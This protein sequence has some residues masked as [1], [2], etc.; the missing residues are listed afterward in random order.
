M[1]SL[2]NLLFLPQQKHFR[3]NQLTPTWQPPLIWPGVNITLV[4]NRGEASEHCSLA[5]WSKN[6]SLVDR[7]TVRPFHTP[8][9]FM[10]AV[11]LSHAVLKQDPKRWSMAMRQTLTVLLVPVVTTSGHWVHV[12]QQGITVCTGNCFCSRN[13]SWLTFPSSPERRSGSRETLWR[14]ER[15]SAALTR[16][17]N[18]SWLVS[19]CWITTFYRPWRPC[20]WLS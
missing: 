8:I 15:E 10:Y 7:L 18:G 19:T 12:K 9:S 14:K 11:K 1:P 20:Y 2:L 6:G 4:G 16:Q 3:C 13:S 5:L 17:C